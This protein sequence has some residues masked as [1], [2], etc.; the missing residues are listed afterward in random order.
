MDEIEEAVKTLAELSDFQ[1]SG[2]LLE[3][4]IEFVLTHDIA[5]PL[6]WLIE[7]GFGYKSLRTRDVRNRTL[8]PMLRRNN[9]RSYGTRRDFALI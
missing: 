7:N 8:F 5:I 6:A 9:G 1:M 3:D 4:E 2:A